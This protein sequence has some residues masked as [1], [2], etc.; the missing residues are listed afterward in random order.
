MRKLC[1]RALIRTRGTPAMAFT[2]EES[3]VRLSQNLTLGCELSCTTIHGETFRGNLMAKD[4][5]AML[6]VISI[7]PTVVLCV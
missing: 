5:E 7:L 3:R 6:V 4:E 1:R 2:E